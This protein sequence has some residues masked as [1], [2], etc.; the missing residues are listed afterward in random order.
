MWLIDGHNL[1]GQLQDL[2]L[3]DPHD[4]AKLCMAIRRYMMRSRAKGVVIFDNGLP[5][6]VS[7]ELSNSDL[8]V[9]FAPPRTK[10]DHLLMERAKELHHVKNF[11]LVTSDRQIV[12]LAYAYGVETMASEEFALLLGF[13]P[14]EIENAP[15]A[16]DGKRQVKIVYDK[17]PNP[18]VSPQEIAYWLP[19][20]KRKLHEVRAATAVEKIAERQR[21][22][23]ARKARKEAARAEAEKARKSQY[24]PPFPKDE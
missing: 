18:I 16:A 2:S 14:V 19:I 3:E 5:G 23:E 20:F 4:E 15:P 6:G 9:I 10:A 12:R 21:I 13:R 11:V 17:D 8:T 1:I 22:E 24:K 7:R